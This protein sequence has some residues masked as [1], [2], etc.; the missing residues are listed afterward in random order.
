M[1]NN[2]CSLILFG[3]YNEEGGTTAGC[4]ILAINDEILLRSERAVGKDEYFILKDAF[5]KDTPYTEEIHKIISDIRFSSCDLTIDSDIIQTILR[6]SYQKNKDPN[7]EGYYEYF[8]EFFSFNEWLDA[9]MGWIGK[10]IG[11]FDLTNIGHTIRM[12]KPT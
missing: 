9:G 2:R 5:V 12:V 6:S 11:T 1:L 8:E 7:K 4:F 3:E 10:C